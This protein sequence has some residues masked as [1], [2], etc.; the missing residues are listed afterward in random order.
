MKHLPSR[1][2]LVVFEGIDGAGKTTQASLVADWL[3]SQGLAVVASKEPT[4]GPW[5]RMIRES[6]QTGRLDAEAELDAFLR[7]RR[8]HVVGLIEPSLASGSIVIL[9]RYYFSTAAYQGI[10]PP[11]SVDELIRINE[12]FAPLPDL[13][14]ILDVE[15]AVGARRIHQRGDVA[16]EF[17]RIADLERS[18]EVFRGFRDRPFTMFLDGSLPVDDLQKRIVMEILRVAENRIA[19]DPKLNILQKLNATIE[20]VRPSGVA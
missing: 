3:E 11:H 8:E 14:V 2:I 5:G 19:L 15:P 18:R 10:R 17:E 9:D 12:E 7:D 16:N 4:S 20:L 1:G 6:A 13:L